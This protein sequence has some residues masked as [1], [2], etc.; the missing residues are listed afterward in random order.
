M[1][2]KIVPVIV[3]GGGDLAT[4][5]VWRLRRAGYPVLVLETER[6]LVVRRMVSCAQAVFSGSCSVEGMETRLISS[7][8]EFDASFV[9]VLTDPHGE[10]IDLIRPYIL[11]DAIMAKRNT[12]TR[13]EMAPLTIALGPGFT[14]PPDV[15]C[16][17]E[18]KRG[19]S[20]GRVVTYGA[21]AANTGIPGV[22]GGYG[23]ERLLR[24]PAEGYLE[25]L[26]DIGDSVERGAAVATVSGE[27]V[28]AQISGV[29]RGLIHHSVPLH[30]G[31]KIGDVDARNIRSYA[32]TISDK[33]LAV[34]G[35]VME[36]IS[37]LFAAV[38]RGDN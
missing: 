27:P 9:N 13:R 16:V 23:A 4:G 12:G 18:T 32:F 29:V 17:V 8:Q 31:M 22:N 26:C 33:A 1:T 11:I 6:P 36:A 3:R 24:S 34:A 10:C 35:G 5:V 20:L 2:G 30:A 25:P 7:P 14:A 21:A 15:H 19:H 37:S 28:R 38:Y